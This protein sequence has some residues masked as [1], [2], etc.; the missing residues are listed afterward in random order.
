[1]D[2]DTEAYGISEETFGRPSSCLFVNHFVFH[3]RRYASKRLRCD[4]NGYQ[5]EHLRLREGEKKSS[6]GVNIKE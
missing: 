4:C 2:M 1:M 6:D 3:W 5:D